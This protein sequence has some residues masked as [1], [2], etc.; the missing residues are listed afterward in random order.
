M[1]IKKVF[2]AKIGGGLSFISLLFLPLSKGCGLTL[3]GSEVIR[4]ADVPPIIKLLLI[5]SILC[6]I[7]SFLLKSAHALFISG[8]AG[9]GGL[10][11]AYTIARQDIP[12]ELEI[13]AIL[14]IIGFGLILIEGFMQK[15]KDET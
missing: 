8:G 6:A 10:L 12:V 3:T 7:V 2:L 9:L 11:G 1:D 13:G 4:A 14:T 5:I 15:Q